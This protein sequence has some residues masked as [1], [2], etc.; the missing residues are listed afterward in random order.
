LKV[1]KKGADSVLKT[2][3]FC[4][5]LAKVS[6]RLAA[7]KKSLRKRRTGSGNLKGKRLVYKENKVYF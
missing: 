3:C 1:K 6:G 4:T 2:V 7:V 5:E